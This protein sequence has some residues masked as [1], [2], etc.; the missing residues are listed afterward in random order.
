MK[1]TSPER[2]ILERNI[3]QHRLPNGLLV[4]TEHIPG[5]WAMEDCSQKYE[6]KDSQTLEFRFELKPKEKVAL[7]M[8]C[9]RRNLR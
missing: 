8:N 1:M 9:H 5:E 7:T 3:A 4:L 6:L 2:D